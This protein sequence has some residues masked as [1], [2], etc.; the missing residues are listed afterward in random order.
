V[1]LCV[2]TS[3]KGKSFVAVVMFHVAIKLPHFST[4]AGV[5]P[6]FEVCISPPPNLPST[7]WGRMGKLKAIVNTTSTL[8]VYIFQFNSYRN[9]L[10]DAPQSYFVSPDH[11]FFFFCFL[12][13]PHLF[14]SLL[15][16]FVVLIDTSAISASVSVCNSETIG[17]YPAWGPEPHFR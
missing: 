2:R 12:P 7:L 11:C 3:D 4:S 5:G 8:N 9:C 17:D 16:F 6:T 14:H 15:F 1:G 13:L 10:P